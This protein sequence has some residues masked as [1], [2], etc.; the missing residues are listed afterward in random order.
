[1]FVVDIGVKMYVSGETK[2]GSAELKRETGQ[3]LNPLS[4]E[5]YY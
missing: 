1:M 3:H 5:S 4:V 2:D